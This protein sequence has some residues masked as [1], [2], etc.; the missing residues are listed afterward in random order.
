VAPRPAK[1]PSPGGAGLGYV[2]YGLIAREIKRVD[3]GYRCYAM[4]A[5]SS[6]VMQHARFASQHLFERPAFW[7][8]AFARLKLDGAAADDE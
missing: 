7:G 6:L 2:A 1:K 5:Q 4:S 8:A 3:S